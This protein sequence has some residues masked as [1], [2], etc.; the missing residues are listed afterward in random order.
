LLF[1]IGELTLAQAQHIAPIA[2]LW[3]ETCIRPLRTV[4]QNMKQLETDKQ[5]E[6][7]QSLREQVKTIELGAEKQLIEDLELAMLSHQLSN[8]AAN[9]ASSNDVTVVNNS[10]L[11]IK[12][13]GLDCVLKTER[14]LDVL[15]V[16]LH[17]AHPEIEYYALFDIVQTNKMRPLHER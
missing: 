13:L 14:A 5:P 11:N 12:Q 17:A 1:R 4:R 3:T 8:E 15:V 7:W 16:I 10:L 9:I 6:T 2:S